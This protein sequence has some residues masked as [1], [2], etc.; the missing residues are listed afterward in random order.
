M[1]LKYTLNLYVFC[2]LYSLLQ[3]KKKI[4]FIVGRIMWNTHWPGKWF[5]VYVDELSF[6][7]I[8]Y[9]IHRLIPTF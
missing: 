5:T 1:L 9:N 2:N 6:L 8:I 7:N 4:N 3:F